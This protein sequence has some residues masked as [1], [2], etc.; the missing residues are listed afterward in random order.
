LQR[1]ERLNKDRVHPFSNIT[2]D[3]EKLASVVDR[4][5]GTLRA[6]LDRELAGF[7]ELPTTFDISLNAHVPVSM[8]NY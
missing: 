1:L 8:A 5:E 6:V 2:R 4:D 7:N 3:F